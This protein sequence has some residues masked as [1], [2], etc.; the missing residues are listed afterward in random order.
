MTTA[1]VRVA[2]LRSISADEHEQIRETLSG[3][4]LTPDQA[5]FGGTPH[6]FLDLQNDPNRHVFLVYADELLV[7]IGSLLTGEVPHELWPMGTPAV[8][9]RG[10]VI[11]SRMQG[12]GIG[13]K[14]VLQV[15]ELAKTVDPHAHHLTLSVNQRNPGAK[16]AYEK[17]G[18]IV[19]SEPY[20]GGPLGPQDIMYI[21]LK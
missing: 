14:A 3:M 15:I 8:Q 2:P 9:F 4:S 16:R 7:G 1:T 6:S 13:T 21:A 18:F 5:Q 20:L 10:F 17:A 19:L 11:D 12:K